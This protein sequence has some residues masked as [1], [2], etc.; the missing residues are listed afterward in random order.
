[1]AYHPYGHVSTTTVMVES[2]LNGGTS[3]IWS[4]INHHGHGR[5]MFKPWHINDMVMYQPPWS[6]SNHGTS[7]ITFYH[8]MTSIRW[9]TI[10]MVNFHIYIKH[11]VRISH[12]KCEEKTCLTAISRFGYWWY[13][14]IWL[15]VIFLATNPFAKYS[16]NKIIKFSR[17]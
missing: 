1:M 16:S 12:C 9:T 5:I 11:S 3:S 14:W 15:L 6:W 2:W 4:C 17:I 10:V 13:F 7:W 8:S